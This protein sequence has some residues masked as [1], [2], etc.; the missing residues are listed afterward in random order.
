MFDKRKKFTDKEPDEEVAIVR[1]V[2][3]THRHHRSS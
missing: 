1:T 2:D 3:P